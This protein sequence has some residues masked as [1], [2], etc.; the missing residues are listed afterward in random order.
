MSSA[1]A[2][3]L[4]SASSV[5]TNVELMTALFSGV[6]PWSAL[7]IWAVKNGPTAVGAVIILFLINKSY[8][9]P[10]RAWAAKTAERVDVVLT[11]IEKFI[12]EQR[13]FVGEQKLNTAFFVEAHHR[14]GPAIEEIKKGIDEMDRQ[15]DAIL[16]V[17]R[18]GAKEHSEL[19]TAVAQ[20]KNLDPHGNITDSQLR[21]LLMVYT[22]KV[23]AETYVW[24]V[25][26]V[27]ANG[28]LSNSDGVK[29]AYSNRRSKVIGKYISQM[30]MWRHRGVS[31]DNWATPGISDL[32]EDLFRGLYQRQLALTSGNGGNVIDTYSWMQH[33][34]S[35]IQGA[36]DAW[37]A[38]LTK[39]DEYLA[40]SPLVEGSS[41][42]EWLSQPKDGV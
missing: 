24:W 1:T 9:K 23:M 14:Y 6:D 7:A 22:G 2:E 18:H 31:M 17:E 10:A 37:I 29:E 30:G 42:I 5:S 21:N 35:I 39:L 41:D 38:G 19:A 27:G 32:F 20:M 12:R 11:D 28:V 36:A 15:L 40:N 3:A 34:V 16:E 25:E 26:R 13:E 33:R 4:S 8:I